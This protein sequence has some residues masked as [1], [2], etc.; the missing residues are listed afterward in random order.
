MT[1]YSTTDL[2][3]AARLQPLAGLEPV[4]HA[5]AIDLALQPP[6]GLGQLLDLLSQARPSTTC[7]QSGLPSSISAR[8][9]RQNVPD[10]LA[11]DTIGLGRAAL[12]GEDEAVNVAAEAIG[13]EPENP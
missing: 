5:E 7:R 13:V 8:L 12:G 3:F 10:Q 9:M 4:E 2:D 1:P 6:S 11:E